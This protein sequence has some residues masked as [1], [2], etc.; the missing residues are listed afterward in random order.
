MGKPM[1]TLAS[2]GVLMTARAGQA[3]VRRPR[4]GTVAHKPVGL[5]VRTTPESAVGPTILLPSRQ[6]AA[7]C[8]SLG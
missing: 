1:W 2:P 8:G 6:P 4:V 5:A 7:S 3:A